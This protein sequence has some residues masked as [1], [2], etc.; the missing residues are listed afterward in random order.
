MKGEKTMKKTAMKTTKIMVAVL[1]ALTMASMNLIVAVHASTEETAISARYYVLKRDA[2]KYAADVNYYHSLG[3]GS[4]VQP[5]MLLDEVDAIAA[6]IVSIPDTAKAGLE[7]D[8]TIEWYSMK[9]VKP[10]VWHVDGMIVK[11]SQPTIDNE[12]EEEASDAAA[13]EEKA[14]E[15]AEEE[16]TEAVEEDSVRNLMKRMILTGDTNSYDISKYKMSYQEVNSIFLDLSANE[17]RVAK[18]N[19]FNLGLKTVVEN[20]I[21]T[22][23]GFRGMDDQ[24][25]DRMEKTT[26]SIETVKN[27]ISTGMTDLEKVLIA[28]D[29]V[30]GNTVYAHKTNLAYTASGPLALGYAICYGYSEAMAVLLG[31]MGLETRVVTSKSMNH[32]WIMVNLDGEWFHI[33]ATWDDTRSASSGEISRAFFLK[34][35]KEFTDA[36]SNKHYGWA[37]TSITTELPT[38]TSTR[39]ANSFLNSV[40]G[41]MRYADGLWYYVYNGELVRSDIEGNNRETLATG[42]GLKLTSLENG[43]LYYTMNGSQQ[44]MSI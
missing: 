22:M 21:C 31:E 29:Y 5:E 4:I 15:E 6:K 42:S 25:A 34:T 17:C 43:V 26:Q 44:S 33:D 12:T 2:K 24:V 10:G 16:T 20:K 38:S 27:S 37:S 14:E 3:Y 19:Y 11:Q 13:E 7:A 35:D 41:E 40:V 18:G 30:V 8:E 39:F 28:H 36:A 23:L 32:V 9:E 1:I